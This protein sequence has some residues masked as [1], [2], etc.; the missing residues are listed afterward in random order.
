VTWANLFRVE[1]RGRLT[2]MGVQ[3]PSPD[4]DAAAC[5]ST[6]C[7]SVGRAGGSWSL[8]FLFRSSRSPQRTP[9]L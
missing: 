4:R 7:S 3:P 6:S 1:A 5:A 2:A 8:S 9:F